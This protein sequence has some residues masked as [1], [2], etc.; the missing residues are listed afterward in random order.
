[1]DR[2]EALKKITWDVLGKR[3]GKRFYVKA[4]RMI[5][6][7]AWSNPS[8]LS[9]ARGIE[10]IVRLFVSVEDARALQKKYREFFKD[11]LS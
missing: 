3:P 8:L 5:D 4:D 7:A 2:A 11:R 9:A 1:M 10:R 6:D